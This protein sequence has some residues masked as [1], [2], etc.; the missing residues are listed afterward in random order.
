MRLFKL[1]LPI[2]TLAEIETKKF[3]SDVNKVMDI[4]VHSLYKTKDIFLRELVSNSADALE[5]IRIGNDDLAIKIKSVGD[6]L[7]IEDNGVGMTRDELVSNL[8]T[9]ANSGTSKLV[10]NPDLIGKFGVGF[11]SVFLVSDNVT[12]TTKSDQG[13]QFVWKSDSKSY[14]LEK[15]NDD[16]LKRGTRIELKLRENAQEFGD[17]EVLEQVL[18]KHSEFVKFPIYLW[19]EK[20]VESQATKETSS[21]S[22]EAKDEDEVVVEDV[23]ETETKKEPEFVT[24]ADWERVNSQKPIWLR[25]PSKVTQEEYDDFFKQHYKESKKPL[26]VGHFK[27][28]GQNSFNVLMFIPESAPKQFLSPDNEKTKNQIELFVRRVFI[29]DEFV[30]FLPNWLSFVKVVLDS[31]DLPLN[32]NREHIQTHASLKLVQKKIVSKALDLLQEVAE[33]DED[34]KEV[35]DNYGRAFKVGIHES[36]DVASHQ[37]KLM[38]LI[39]FESTTNKFTSL[40]AYKE[41]MIKDQKQIYFSTGTSLKAARGSPMAER[42][43]TKGVEVLLF[44]DPVDEYLAVNDMKQYDSIPL[45]DVAKPGVLFDGNLINR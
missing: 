4:L 19:K 18:K 30:G 31:D 10:E 15:G 23:P 14:T 21:E 28:E 7:I 20:Q 36:R 42:L 25:N 26:K 13:E 35:Y 33:K 38:D 12:V 16:D 32:V 22:K 1:L 45:Q 29:S 17:P 8:G 41:R 27:I 2:F 37:A 40:K 34:Y 3:D 11:Y 5:K 43:M 44:V 9:I 24:V 39:R 6:K